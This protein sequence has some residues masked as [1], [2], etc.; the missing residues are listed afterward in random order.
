MIGENKRADA[1]HA[2]GALIF[3]LFISLQDD[4]METKP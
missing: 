3:L 2:F 1:L 4:A